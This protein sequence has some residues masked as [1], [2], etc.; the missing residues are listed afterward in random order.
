MGFLETT[1]WG[2][3]Q[4]RHATEQETIDLKPSPVSPLR[5]KIPKDLPTHGV[6]IPFQYMHRPQSQNMVTPLRLRYTPYT[7]MDPL[8]DPAPA[9]PSGSRIQ[10][11]VA[12]CRVPRCT[13]C[14]PERPCSSFEEGCQKRDHRNPLKTQVY[15]PYTIHQI[16][17]TVYYILYTISNILYTYMDPLGLEDSIRL[18]CVAGTELRP[19]GLASLVLPGEARGA[20]KARRVILSKTF[21]SF[22]KLTGP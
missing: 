19:S 12:T 11:R 3:I 8:G 6:Q 16:L 1:L 21:G 9:G 5:T 17:Y 10:N 20:R 4:P 7:Y 13:S 14:A 18:S 2:R 15:V 22:P